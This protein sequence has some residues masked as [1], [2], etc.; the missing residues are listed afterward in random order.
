MMAIVEDICMDHDKIK[1]QQLLWKLEDL[2]QEVREWP[3]A[4]DDNYFHYVR[5]GFQIVKVC[6]P[7]LAS[8]DW[9]RETGMLNLLYVT[10]T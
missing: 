9:T 10:M 4:I 5:R 8:L 2:Y 3:E 6:G 1:C 7:D